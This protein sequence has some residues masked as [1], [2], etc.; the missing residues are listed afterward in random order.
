MRGRQMS[1]PHNDHH[2]PRHAV[3]TTCRLANVY[4]KGSSG[5]VLVIEAASRSA[6]SGALL[7]LN[8]ATLFVR[9]MGGFGGDRGPPP[10][11]WAGA[12]AVAGGTRPDGVDEFATSRSAALLYRLNADANPLHVDASL[13]AVGGFDRPILHGLASFGIA[14]RAILRRY[15]GGEVGRMTRMRARFTKHVFPGDTLVVESWRCGNDATGAAE[16]IAFRV[17]VKRAPPHPPAPE[18]DDV[19]LAAGTAHVSLAGG[20][21]VRSRL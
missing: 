10:E 19:V 7:A 9:G 16:I 4:D 18:N 17:R 1:I 5:A 21:Q 3:V 2:R 11:P 15:A 8:R 13:A 12:S 14:G 20:L 6:E